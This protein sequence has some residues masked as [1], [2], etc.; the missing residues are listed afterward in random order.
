MMKVRFPEG[1]TLTGTAETIVR[2]MRDS[3]WTVGDSPIE[4]Y[5]ERVRSDAMRLHGAEIQAGSPAEFLASLANHNMII[6]EEVS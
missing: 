1:N 3:H 4:T 5:M 2:V 6:I